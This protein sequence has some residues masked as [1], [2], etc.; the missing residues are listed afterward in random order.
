MK[1]KALICKGD[2]FGYVAEVPS[3][4][5]SFPTTIQTMKP[6]RTFEKQ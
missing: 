1:F 6:S 5:G 4:P 3:L 2:D